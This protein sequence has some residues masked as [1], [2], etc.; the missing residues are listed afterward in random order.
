MQLELLRPLWSG[1]TA[2]GSFMVCGQLRPTARF[3]SAPHPDLPDTSVALNTGPALICSSVSFA[4]SAEA[5]CD[6][7]VVNGRRLPAIMRP[8]PPP[9]GR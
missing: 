2:C 9:A 4:P 6:A 3:E 5:L 1:V 7:L 8:R